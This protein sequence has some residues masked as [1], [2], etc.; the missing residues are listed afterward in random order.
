MPVP[1]ET[2]KSLLLSTFTMA[3]MVECVVFPSKTLAI[4][5]LYIFKAKFIRVRIP[6]NHIKLRFVSF[7]I[8]CQDN[9]YFFRHIN[10]SPV[11]IYATNKFHHQRFQNVRAIT[12][13]QV[14][15]RIFSNILVF[16][17]WN[18]YSL[19]LIQI[20]HHGLSP[21]CTRP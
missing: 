10:T 2:L 12:L 1:I 14:S 4:L 18:L 9:G 3:A 17:P 13:L 6:I 19:P 7:I 20:I 11:V 16:P 8:L 21:L 15:T 5:I